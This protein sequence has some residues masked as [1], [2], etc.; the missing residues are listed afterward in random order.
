MTTYLELLIEDGKSLVM[1][2][3]QQLLH[4]SQILSIDEIL[5]QPTTS[6]NELCKLIS[7]KILSQTFFHH[8]NSQIKKHYVF[9]IY[10]TIFQNIISQTESSLSPLNQAQFGKLVKLRFGCSTKRMGSRGASQYAYVG[11]AIIPELYAQFENQKEWKELMQREK[12]DELI[13]WLKNRE[14]RCNVLERCQLIL[15]SFMEF[16]IERMKLDWKD[17]QDHDVRFEIMDIFNGLLDEKM[18]NKINVNY[19]PTM[20]ILKVNIIIKIIEIVQMLN[21]NEII[22][23]F[24]YLTSKILQEL[25]YKGKSTFGSFWIIKCLFDE[26]TPYIIDILITT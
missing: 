6:S 16:D 10:T 20:D 4:L 5:S 18:L 22:L 26:L 11:L 8:P 2:K 14:V 24:Q 13:Q 25:T 23:Q 7:L 15:K 1:S 17:V 19:E 21:K 9:K 12:K 3:D